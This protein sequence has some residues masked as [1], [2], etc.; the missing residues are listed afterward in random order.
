MRKLT[1]ILF[2]LMAA[3]TAHASDSALE[4]HAAIKAM[5]QDPAFLGNMPLTNTPDVY[6]NLHTNEEMWIENLST[7]GDDVARKLVPNIP[8]VQDLYTQYR[9][10]GAT[11]AQSFLLTNLVVAEKIEEGKLAEIGLSDSQPPS[12]PEAVSPSTTD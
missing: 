6:R 8:Q 4:D 10:L 3:C 11:P 9:D 5:I 2:L 12:E 1:G 7:V